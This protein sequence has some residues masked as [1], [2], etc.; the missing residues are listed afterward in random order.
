VTIDAGD[1]PSE[2]VLV[3]GGWTARFDGTDL[4]LR[5]GR[6]LWTVPPQAIRSVELTPDR[7]VRIELTGSP[8]DLGDAVRIPFTSLPAAKAFTGRLLLAL[9]RRADAVGGSAIVAA[10]APGRRLALPRRLGRVLVLWGRAGSATAVFLGLC[11][12]RGR[13]PER[14]VADLGL[15]VL[16]GF[17]AWALLYYYGWLGYTRDL[18]A[19]RRHGVTVTGRCVGTAQPPGPRGAYRRRLS[20][21]TLEG[22]SHTVLG[23]D[24]V[25]GI[26]DVEGPVDVT[27][28]V[29]DPTR[30]AA[31]V[32]LLHYC[33]AAAIYLLGTA[34]LACFLLVLL[35]P[36]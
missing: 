24:M 18:V 1:R 22:T 29:R 34:A 4:R 14:A 9:S 28:D 7:W 12:L 30:A 5:R 19:L 31:P 11:L 25:A 2:I 36:P 32:G 10:P 23:C 16:F 6:N 21:T 3:G 20:F 13:G 26:R 35:S 33:W 15:A 8:A 27:Y 17:P